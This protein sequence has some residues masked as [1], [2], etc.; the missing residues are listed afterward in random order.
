M[1]FVGTKI[2]VC[3][4]FCLEVSANTCDKR[5]KKHKKK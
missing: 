1:K 2:D 4:D 5:R 3:Y